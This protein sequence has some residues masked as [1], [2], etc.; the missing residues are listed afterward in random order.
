[1][2][3]E[4]TL[5]VGQTPPSLKLQS[6]GQRPSLQYSVSSCVLHGLPETR[7]FW[8]AWRTRVLVGLAAMPSALAQDLLHGLQFSQA[9]RWQSIGQAYWLQSVV[10]VV[11]PHWAPACWV[12]TTTVR[13]WY[14]VPPPQ[15]L[16]QEEGLLQ[17]VISQSTWHGPVP[18]HSLVSY[19]GAQAR[20]PAMGGVTMVRVLYL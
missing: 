12:S 10:H 2:V 18:M 3:D 19:W 6:I 13:V 8:S 5:Q 15:D 7:G 20:P 9:W 14:R 16:V 11:L 17:A 4:Q 1:V